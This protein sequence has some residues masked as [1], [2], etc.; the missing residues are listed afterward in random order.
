MVK[1]DQD[2]IDYLEEMI[3]TWLLD[4]NQTAEDLAVKLVRYFN[5][6]TTEQPELPLK[7][8]AELERYKDNLDLVD[9]LQDIPNEK[10]LAP[11]CREWA[12]SDRA[13]QKL[14]QAWFI[15]YKIQGDLAI[16]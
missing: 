8:A 7:V 1:Y 12:T 13:F 9:F 14:V 3:D 4:N 16:G 5:K 10:G 15:G 2:E 11:C 6:S